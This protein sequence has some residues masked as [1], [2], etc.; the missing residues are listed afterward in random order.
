MSLLSHEPTDRK[1]T[2]TAGAKACSQRV[3]QAVQ[4]HIS[5][6]EEVFLGCKQRKAVPRLPLLGTPANCE[7]VSALGRLGLTRAGF[8]NVFAQ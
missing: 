3:D 5:L 1:E 2:S 8:Q 6:D 4:K 7:S